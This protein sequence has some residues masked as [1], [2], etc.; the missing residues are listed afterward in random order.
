MPWHF[1]IITFNQ[2]S[3]KNLCIRKLRTA[4]KKVLLILIFIGF[5]ACQPN[6][7]CK[8]FKT[9]TFYIMNADNSIYTTIVRKE[10][11]Q[12]EFSEQNAQ[13][14]HIT[15]EWIDDCTYRIN[16]DRTKSLLEDTKVKLMSENNGLLIQ[17]INIS[18]NC[19]TYKATLNLPNGEKQEQI[20]KMC[21]G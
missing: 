9:G 18:G 11:S 2:Q 4:M 1:K 5:N 13:P 7:T 8:D 14:T 15:I 19:M 10:N 16:Y 20:G 3:T 21:K 12:L 17:K 6:L